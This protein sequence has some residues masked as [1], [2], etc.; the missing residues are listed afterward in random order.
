M[1]QSCWHAG[2]HLVSYMLF[3]WCYAPH[4]TY[5]AMVV[6]RH[7]AYISRWRDLGRTSLTQYPPSALKNGSDCCAHMADTSMSSIEL[8][9]PNALAAMT[10]LRCSG[11][12][13]GS[14]LLAHPV[15]SETSRLQASEKF[16]CF[17]ISGFGA[18]TLGQP[19]RQQRKISRRFIFVVSILP[20]P[21]WR[22]QMQA[23]QASS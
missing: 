18:N 17:G 12:V 4:K 6:L 5:D 16:Q 3:K 20:A 21:F 8:V 7:A 19:Q 1:W 14:R 9:L 10:I 23:M 22:R 13:Q 11:L 2:D 15:A